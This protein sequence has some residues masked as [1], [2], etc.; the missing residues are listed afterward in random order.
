MEVP[1][2]GKKDG[3]WSELRHFP[4]CGVFNVT[5]ALSHTKEKLQSRK[6]G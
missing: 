5:N 2:A 4:C 6:T 3:I 1:A